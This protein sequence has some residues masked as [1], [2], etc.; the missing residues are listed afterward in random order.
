MAT[1]IGL[2]LTI[3]TG[4]QELAEMNGNYIFNLEV[5]PWSSYPAG[6]GRGGIVFWLLS[7]GLLVLLVCSF[8]SSK[9]VA[10]HSGITG[11]Q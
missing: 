1:L 5:S 4:T 11:P 8:H 6:V 3:N 9:V 10:A 2:V 7:S